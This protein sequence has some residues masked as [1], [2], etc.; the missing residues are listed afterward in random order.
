MCISSK[1]AKHPFKVKVA[2]QR[3]NIKQKYHKFLLRLIS[4]LL[5]IT[6]EQL[7]C[8]TH[9]SHSTFC[10][11]FSHT[12]TLPQQASEFFPAPSWNSNAEGFCIYEHGCEL[13]GVGGGLAQTKDDGRW[14]PYL[15][16]I[17]YTQTLNTKQIQYIFMPWKKEHMHN[18][19]D[20]NKRP[21]RHAKASSTFCWGLCRYGGKFKKNH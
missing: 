16:H 8:S 21:S 17:Q 18:I 2:Y 19:M 1:Y 13:K 5:F 10:L 14:R 6:L 9:P 20:R 11:P 15:T 3:L 12:H 4:V 7:H